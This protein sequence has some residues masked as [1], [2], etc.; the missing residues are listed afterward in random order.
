MAWSSTKTPTNLHGQSNST[1]G[2]VLQ[3]SPAFVDHPH[4]EA[5]FPRHDLRAVVGELAGHEHSREGRPSRPLAA[6]FGA[7]NP[8]AVHG[9][10]GIQNRLNDNLD[11]SGRSRHSGAPTRTAVPAL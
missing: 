8:E 5:L 4:V 2:A 9:D 7:L 1:I 11:R 10:V 3:S 6:G